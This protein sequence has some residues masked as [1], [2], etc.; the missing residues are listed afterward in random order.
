[1]PSTTDYAGVIVDSRN[2]GK[3]AQMFLANPRGV[4]YDAWTSDVDRART[5]RPTSTGTRSGRSRPR[6]G[7]SRSAFRSR[8]CATPTFREPTWGI[9][10]YRNYPR[11]RR[12]QFFSARL[13]RDVN[14]FICNSSKLSGLANLPH[15]SHLVV[16]PYATATQT[17]AP[18]RRSR[19]LAR[20]RATSTPRSALD[21]K[22]NPLANA[23]VDATINPDFSQV[24]SDAAQIAA[25]ERFA[26]FYPEKRSFFLEG[27]DLFAT[28]FTAVYTRTITRAELGRPASPAGWRDVRTPRSPRTTSGGGVAILPGP[29]G[30]DAALQDFESDVGIVRVRRDLG[31]SFLSAV[32]TGRWIDGGGYNVVGGPDLQWRPRPSDSFTGQALWS[33]SL[34]PN[35]PDLAAEWNGQTLADHAA[36]L[37]WSHGTTHVDWFLQGQ[38]L[39]PE[40]RADDGFIPRGQV[41]QK[42]MPSWGHTV[43]PTDAFVSRARFFTVN[44]VDVEPG[45]D[46]LSQRVSGGVGL[47]GRWNS[48]IR[49]ELN[50][51]QIRVG[52]QLLGRFPSPAPSRREPG[53]ALQL[54]LHRRLTSA[55]RSTSTTRARALGRP[56]SAS[57]RC[58]PATISTCGATPARGG[59]TSTP[60]T[61]TA[62]G[63]SWPRSSAC[64][65]SC[66]SARD[67]SCV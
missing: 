23:A 64:A 32:G 9:L 67:R 10:L 31:R 66:R 20:E 54:L 39:G 35:R 40:F 15:G 45:G 53:P 56:W 61:A 30:S 24:E 43:R 6:A 4:Q 59:S 37:N 2:D 7:T 19:K 25:N 17:G 13:P 52:D 14:C 50:Q 34:T 22:W 58:A 55:R 63:C 42:A 46:V 49:V 41:P 48:F 29:Q 44:W 1:M 36:L 65:S 62:G 8:R 28:P 3:T 51:D 12:Y 27:V 5:T 33:Q 11:D 38:D 21:V 18:S 47:D 26:L 57:S 16:A 60:A